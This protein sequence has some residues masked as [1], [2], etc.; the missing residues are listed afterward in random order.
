MLGLRPNETQHYPIHQTIHSNYIPSPQLRREQPND[1]TEEEIIKEAEL[2][3]KQAERTKCT[4]DGDVNG[5]KS[6]G[7]RIER[8]KSKDVFLK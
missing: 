1:L 5:G 3:L 7:G 4:T 2:V 8:K 6:R